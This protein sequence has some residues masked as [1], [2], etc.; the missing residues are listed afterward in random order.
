MT[1]VRQRF[2][3]DFRGDLRE[4]YDWYESR[5]AGLGDRFI[6]EVWASLDRIFEDAT[7]FAK[8]RRGRSHVLVLPFP[9]VIVFTST[10]DEVLVFGIVHSS[11][12]Q[13]D[14]MDSKF[15]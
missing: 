14:L 8:N 4:A 3:R 6:S 2:H 15:E 10:P 9:Y 11:R 7:R 5:Q 1:S 12:R 13:H